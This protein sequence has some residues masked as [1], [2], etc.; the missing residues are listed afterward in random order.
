MLKFVKAFNRVISQKGKRAYPGRLPYC[1][2]STAP[3]LTVSVES[4]KVKIE[5]AASSIQPV[6][7]S[8]PFR[9]VQKLSEMSSQLIKVRF[10]SS[11]GCS[12]MNDKVAS[13]A[14]VFTKQGFGGVCKAN[15]V[16]RQSA[17][18]SET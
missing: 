7:S 11:S 17:V 1:P 12:Q 2:H 3:G 13:W 5:P 4:W 9:N 14:C 8:A 10:F 6:L 18:S 15:Q 16:E